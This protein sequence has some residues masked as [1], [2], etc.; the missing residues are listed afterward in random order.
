M[1][2]NF[3]MELVRA[4]ELA[5]LTAALHQ[6]QGKP[7]ELLN[8][9][10]ESL[11]RG[12]N[13]INVKGRLVIDRLKGEEFVQLPVE[14]GSGQVDMDLTAV[15]VEGFEA[16]AQGKNNAASYAAI[17]KPGNLRPLPRMWMNMLVVPQE[18]HGLVSIDQSPIINIKRVA[19]A[20]G[21]YTENVTVCVLD[22]PRHQELIA[23]IL[24]CGARIKRLEAG[25]ISGALA[26]LTGSA[27]LFMGIGLAPDAVM[28]SAAIRCLGG[29]LEGRLQP[30][31]EMQ[32]EQ[33]KSC[34]LKE[35]AVL[36]VENLVPTQEVSFAAT[37]ITHGEFLGGV[38]FTRNGAVTH[39]FV[40]RGESRTFRR[41]ETTHFFDHVPVF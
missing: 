6:G 16:T 22:V 41:M 23:Q 9:S 33:I 3:G 38:R 40:A 34:K 35:G 27:D 18:A 19:R 15:A 39:S 2:K 10:R 32:K 20:L 13:R 17:A 24:E 30:T 37:G 36:R 4:T 14:V 11:I 5:A 21:K 28:I 12:L 31:S 25:E 29:Y 26:A 1:D 8:A 7:V